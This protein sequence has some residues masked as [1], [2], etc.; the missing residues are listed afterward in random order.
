MISLIS[1]ILEVDVKQ[2]DVQGR[3]SAHFTYK[4]LQ[5]PDKVFKVSIEN[6]KDLDNGILRHI[7]MFKDHP[8]FFPE[9]FRI[10][11]KG[12]E[13]EKLDV[14]KA[15]KEFKELDDVLKQNK[16]R[17]ALLLTDI[18]SGKSY[19]IAVGNANKF[20]QRKYP[21]LVGV[22]KKWCELIDDIT[23]ETSIHDLDIHKFNFGYS[24]Q[25]KLKM[26]DI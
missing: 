20:L 9:V 12:V 6:G 11:K 13:L 15:T 26:L 4:S 21:K 14:E 17:L 19:D 24:K 1:I 2:K 3:G 7:K 16:S 18:N 22:F 23:K 10:F 5:D 8:K 25:G